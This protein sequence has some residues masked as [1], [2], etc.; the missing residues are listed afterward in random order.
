MPAPR[1]TRLK[2]KLRWFLLALL[3]WIA[4]FQAAHAHARH[5]GSSTATPGQEESK[6]KI[7]FTERLKLLSFWYFLDPARATRWLEHPLFGEKASSELKFAREFQVTGLVADRV[8]HAMDT[9]CRVLHSAGV[10]EAGTSCPEVIVFK[11]LPGGFPHIWSEWHG[12][13]SAS[14]AID[15]ALVEELSDKEL[16]AL[17]AWHFGQLLFSAQAKAWQ[18]TG[19]ALAGGAWNVGQHL[20]TGDLQADLKDFLKRFGI[21][22]KSH[23]FLHRDRVPR[24]WN[25]LASSAWSLAPALG[26]HQVLRLRR[27][28]ITM[29]CARLAILAGGSARTATEAMTKAGL[30][31][32]LSNSRVKKT[33]RWAQSDSGRNLIVRSQRCLLHGPFGWNAPWLGMLVL[34]IVLAALVSWSAL[35][36]LRLGPQLSSFALGMCLSCAAVACFATTVRSQGPEVWAGFLFAAIAY[37]V[38][39]LLS[40]SQCSRQQLATR[41]A[42]VDGLVEEVLPRASEAAAGVAL[43]ASAAAAAR[44]I[45]LGQLDTELRTR[46]ASALRGL[47]AKLADLRRLA[48][49]SQGFDR[50][51]TAPTRAWPLSSKLELEIRR[52]L[53]GEM[54]WMRRALEMEQDVALER[55]LFWWLHDDGDGGC[56]GSPRLAVAAEQVDEWV[57]TQ[58]L[59]KLKTPTLSATLASQELLRAP[60]I[61]D[62]A[63][64]QAAAAAM[65]EQYQQ[66][67]GLLKA[68]R[69]ATVKPEETQRWPSL[70][71][72]RCVWQAGASLREIET[73][74]ASFLK[75]SDFH[76]ISTNSWGA[77][78]VRRMQG[79]PAFSATAN[80]ISHDAVRS[81]APSSADVCWASQTTAVL[82]GLCAVVF[83]VTFTI[84]KASAPLW[85]EAAAFVM[86]TTVLLWHHWS[87]RLPR[88]WA[89]LEQCLVAMSGR[90]GQM[91]AQ[92]RGHDKDYPERLAHLKALVLV[93]GIQTAQNLDY[94]TLCVQ[95]EALK[96]AKAKCD[97]QSRRPAVPPLGASWQISPTAGS[98]LTTEAPEEFTCRCMQLLLAVLPR[99][100][101]HGQRLVS[102]DVDVHR[103]MEWFDNLARKKELCTL[104]MSPRDSHAS[105]HRL[106]SLQASLATGQRALWMMYR[107]YDV[108]SIAKP[109]PFQGALTALMISQL[110]P[111]VLE[112]R[113]RLKEGE[114]FTSMLNRPPHDFSVPMGSSRFQ[115]SSEDCTRILGDLDSTSVSN[116]EGSVDS[117]SQASGTVRR[118][119]QPSEGGSSTGSKD[120]GPVQRALADLDGESDTSSI[121]SGMEMD[122]AGRIL[123]ASVTSDGASSDSASS[124]GG[125]SFALPSSMWSGVTY[126]AASSASTVTEDMLTHR[127]PL[128]E[129]YAHALRPLFMT[130][131]DITHLL[132]KF[133]HQVLL[134]GT[135]CGRQFAAHRELLEELFGSLVVWVK[136]PERRGRIRLAFGS[137]FRYA[138][139]PYMLGSVMTTLQ[140]MGDGV[141]RIGNEVCPVVPEENEDEEWAASECAASAA[142]DAAPE[143]GA[144][145]F[146]EVVVPLTEVSSRE[147]FLAELLQSDQCQLLASLSQGSHSKYG[148]RALR[149][150]RRTL[151]HVREATQLLH[152][153]PNDS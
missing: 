71:A 50:Q 8:Q 129:G 88:N 25:A 105:Q 5:T 35:G 23:A 42:A 72:L 82:L 43:L 145:E 33:F 86:V 128:L 48:G 57:N 75:A 99:Q 76:D 17:L 3:S 101:R 92:I 2:V 70:Y 32:Q 133:P 41:R 126:S 102:T 74:V 120:S 47:S 143:Q 31:Q 98:N 30:A 26:I 122:G 19:V 10:P 27:E 14:T 97:T 69:E 130:R 51:V 103:A 153:V 147:L 90:R 144:L 112:R 140:F 135:N 113:L 85:P 150:R 29:A 78:A 117:S 56:S 121:A 115:G 89:L 66:L 91:A 100:G 68:L 37:F 54:L 34:R 9:A 141:Q 118:I 93:Q 53:V 80:A 62:M 40:C 134:G 46:W 83:S 151:R 114:L 123:A 1:T 110:G 132:S 138:E 59:D 58:T 84:L 108:R 96:N 21:L 63:L 77:S 28:A 64:L 55:A 38:A 149:R 39:V 12:K 73:A 16:Q 45:P 24:S 104:P 87:L 152:S 125:G 137:S 142:R 79:H 18:L 60:P 52:V 111:I 36:A 6:H 106:Q 124:A 94:L 127:R 49:A 67:D 20:R 11:A 116:D 148:H 81:S 139:E 107:L 4:A 61:Q 146:E 44:Q 109:A 7:A 119:L 136:S 65:E 13:T 15:L 95:A 131:G 22:P